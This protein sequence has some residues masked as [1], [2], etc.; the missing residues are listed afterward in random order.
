MTKAD[1]TATIKSKL[2]EKL[3]DT[4]TLSDDIEYYFAEWFQGLVD[5]GLQIIAPPPSQEG[6]GAE[7]AP[8]EAA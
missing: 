1:I 7:E 4:S 2:Q 5:Q 6:G 8:P 3:V